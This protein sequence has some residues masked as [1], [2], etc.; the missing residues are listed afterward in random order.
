MDLNSL[1][2]AV[3][4]AIN[5]HASQQ[6]QAGYGGYNNA[7]VGNLL[8]QVAGLFQ[9]HAN[10]TGQ[11]VDT[12]QYGQYGNVLPASQDPLGDPADQQAGFGRVLPASQDPLGDPADQGG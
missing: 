10:A 11:N 9:Q 1:F 12:G 5:D 7:N 3:T 8:N 2:S 6:Q 4:S